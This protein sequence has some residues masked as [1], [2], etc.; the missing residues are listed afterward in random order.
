MN[1]VLETPIHPQLRE[2]LWLESKEMRRDV[3]H[4]VSE[5]IVKMFMNVEPRFYPKDKS[6]TDDKIRCYASSLL[7]HKM[8]YMEF[9]DSIKEGDGLRILHCRHYL[10]L[11]FKVAQ[12]KN[13]S[14]ED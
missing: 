12:R 8:L 10:M 13:Y 3:L 7:S 4:L 1:S 6:Q 5:E 9:L 11:I 14:I 2:N